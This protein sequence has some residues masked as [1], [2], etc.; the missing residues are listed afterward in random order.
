MAQICVG[1]ADELFSEYETLFDPGFTSLAF[2]MVS[3]AILG[4]VFWFFPLPGFGVS[5][6]FQDFAH[7]VLTLL[8][9]STEPCTL[10]RV[11][12]GFRERGV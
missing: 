7:L 9:S 3:W 5:K 4:F 10:F 8:F 12:L 2:P 6:S 1:Y 11:K